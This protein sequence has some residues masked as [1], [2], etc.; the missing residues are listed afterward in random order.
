MIK[1]DLTRD[2]LFDDYALPILRERYL[3]PEENSPQEALVRA[4]KAYCAGDEALAQRIYD[5][6]SKHW[7]MFATPVLSNASSSRGLPISCF[8]NYVGDSRA[9]IC[10]HWTENTWLASMG[11]GIGGYWGHI[12]SDG[13]ATSNGSVSTGSIPFMHVVDSQMLAV[14]QGKTRRGSYAVWTDISHPEVE[15][16]LIMRK[17]GGGDI[18]RKN[19]N[20]HHGIN[21]S[22]AF[23]WAVEANEDW[24]LI[25]PKSKKVTKWVN[26]RDL[27]KKILQMRYE[28][29]EP[30]I[31]FIDTTNRLQPECH[32]ALGL[33]VHSS[34]LCSEIVL[35]INEE[36]TAVCCLSSLNLE[37][38]DEWRNTS[39]V[40]D[41]VTFLD[42]V[43]QNFIDTAPDTMSKAKFSA[44][45]ERSIGIG[46]MGFHAYL[47][48]RE[49]PF[50]SDRALA[51][52]EEIFSHIRFKAERQTWLLGKTRGNAPD[53]DEAGGPE[54]RRNVHLI[55]I[56]PNASTSIICGN[57]SP[58]IEPF[59]ANVYIQ[60]TLNGSNT[61]RNRFLNELLKKKLKCEQ[62]ESFDLH[63][64]WRDIA[65]HQ[66]SVQHLDILSDA[67]KE[68]YKTAGELDQSWVIEHA[69]IRQKYID[70]SQ[71]VN[72]FFPPKV[73]MKYL[74]D[75]H[76]SAWKKGLKTLYYCRTTAAHRVE[77]LYKKV[78]RKNNNIEC[79]GCEG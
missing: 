25:D 35:P 47:Q 21:I 36:R 23:M 55:A 65:A 7:F 57:T 8:L 45:R 53:Y 31:H 22:D 5:Y 17:P 33:K 50:E 1:I 44:M 56:A 60:K 72:L 37:Y 32:K 42:N 34:N 27:W 10:E 63:E 76:F 58:S 13:V 4:A 3:L 61:Y 67:E 78:E 11:G 71:S 30:Y 69:S 19:L 26:A 9:E 70:Q 73:K 41:L 38:Y 20:L 39:I 62:S 16:V 24:E 77:N 48:K 74:H 46:T 40:E 15:E 59:S 28:T 43:L 18:N 6:A 79:I 52:T 49:V 2:K 51:I 64:L 14:S 12:R 29:G 66:G 75:V 54:F 68:I